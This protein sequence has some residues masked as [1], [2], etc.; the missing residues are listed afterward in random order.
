MIE[1]RALVKK[2]SRQEVLPKISSLL[3]ELN[4]ALT[5]KDQPLSRSVLVWVRFPSVAQLEEFI[6]AISLQEL[7]IDEWAIY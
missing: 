4:P 3:T 7:E 6:T 5:L 1:F 2:E